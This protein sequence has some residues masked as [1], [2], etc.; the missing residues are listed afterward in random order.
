MSDD[1]SVARRMRDLDQP[2]SPDPA[3]AD[4]LYL[5]L[6]G[7]L[8]LRGPRAAD[9]TPLRRGSRTRRRRR[10]W[11]LLAVAALVLTLGVAGL[12]ASGGSRDAPTDDLLARLRETGWMRVAVSRGHPQVVVP[13]T[14]GAGFDVEVA[15]A[16]AQ[17][18]RIAL[19]PVNY[20]PG[21][22][23]SL[24]D[25]AH[26]VMSATRVR[27]WHDAGWSL[28]ATAYHWPRYLLARADASFDDP[29]A[30][31]GRRVGLSDQD[32][33]SSLPEGALAVLVATDH[34]CLRLLE[35]GEVEACLSSTLGPPDIT[36]RPALRVLGPPVEVEARGPMV[37][38]S[39]T[40][41]SFAIEVRDAVA[42]LRD[43][44]VLADLS[45]RYLGADLSEPP[46]DS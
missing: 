21:S 46:K 11:P 25:R 28:A 26:L 33:E 5:E 18:L 13:G 14:A 40:T 45:R 15:R 27:E 34:E 29:S 42:A 1:E 10:S 35:T 23:G 2:M 30:L 39:G 38:A 3:F 36:A 8:G 44:G 9:I 19:E 22:I 41:A 43:E 24:V 12:F 32:V 4:R 31:A 17:R 20:V 16:L 37:R 7:E 6:A